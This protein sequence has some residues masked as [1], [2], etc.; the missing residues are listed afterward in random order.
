MRCKV[1][2]SLKI[3]IMEHMKSNDIWKCQTCRNKFDD[4]EA[5]ITLD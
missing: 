5:I 1:F 3:T 2:N 4:K